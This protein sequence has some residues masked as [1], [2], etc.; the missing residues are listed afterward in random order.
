LLLENL[1]DTPERKI[2]SP[3]KNGARTSKTGLK[4]NHLGASKNAT[5]L[6]SK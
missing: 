1:D 6:Y 4:K 5:K 2:K 3:A